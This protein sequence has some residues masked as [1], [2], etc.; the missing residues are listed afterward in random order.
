MD[1]K[2]IIFEKSN[3]IATITF[4]RPDKLN[5]M[6]PRMMGELW[7]AIRKVEDDPNLRV[8]II[9]GAGRGF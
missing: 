1:Y 4:N 8:T 2:E 9:T 7:D 6:T 3:Q 5:A